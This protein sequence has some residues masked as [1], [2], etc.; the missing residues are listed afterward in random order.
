MIRKFNKEVINSVVVLT[1]EVYQNSTI[2]ELEKELLASLEDEHRQFFLYI[3]NN[4]VVGFSEVTFRMDYVEGLDSGGTG[5][6]EG[7]YVQE[8][9]RGLGV[10]RELVSCCQNWSK[11]KGAKGFASDCEITNEESRL[12]H[13]RIGFKEVSRNIHFVFE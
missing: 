12:F 7:I 11:A 10:G 8:D 2:S 13:E 1:K 5:Y 6:L 9:Y 3:I 4:E